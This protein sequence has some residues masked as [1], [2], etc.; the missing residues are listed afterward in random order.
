MNTDKFNSVDFKKMKII[1]TSLFILMVFIF[2]MSHLF[3]SRFQFLSYLK[4]FSEAAMVGALADWFA[5]VA[6][7]RKPFGIPFHTA[8]I[9]NNKDKMGESLGKMVQDNFLTPD[10][11]MNE[12]KKVDFVKEGLGLIKEKEDRFLQLVYGLFPEVLNQIDKDEIKN[13]IVK[14]IQ[15]IK[16]S[17]VIGDILELLTNENKHQDLLDLTLN[18]IRELVTRNKR[19]IVGK[20]R[21]IEIEPGKYLPNFHLP[22]FAARWIANAI[23]VFINKEF[24]DIMNDSSHSLRKKFNNIVAKASKELKDNK[25]LQSTVDEKIKEV[26]LNKTVTIYFDS[27]WLELKDN[28]EEDLKSN[29]SKI[30]KWVKSAFN[31]LIEFIERNKSMRMEIDS[32]IKEFLKEILVEEKDRISSMISEKIKKTPAHEV[33]DLIER[34]VGKD[35][36]YIRINGTLVGGVVGVIIFLFS[37]LL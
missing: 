26:L 32:D 35:L 34:Y 10:N 11:I 8:I 24:E 15:E 7:F 37:K 25:K 36:Q 14:K 31:N 23:I 27:I 29:D 4:V 18:E 30:R 2:I 22:L 5:V 3:E 9:P 19:S 12:F 6:L 21:E 20:I 28:I 1:A 13:A 33:S 16:F 17:K